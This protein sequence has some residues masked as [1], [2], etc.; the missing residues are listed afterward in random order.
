MSLDLI[1]IVDNNGHNHMVG[2][3]YGWRVLLIIAWCSN[4]YAFS[5]LNV[6]TKE[7]ATE[8]AKVNF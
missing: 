5:R 1:T 4:L 3:H 6:A 2:Q 7:F 8:E